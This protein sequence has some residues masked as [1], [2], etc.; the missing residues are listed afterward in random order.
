MP[1][2][3]LDDQPVTLLGFENA[4]LNYSCKEEIIIGSKEFHRR[5]VKRQHISNK[6][7]RESWATGREHRIDGL[8]N[9]FSNWLLDSGFR[10]LLI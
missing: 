1:C 4:K 8:F 7:R 5:S 3:I 10:S 2:I 6:Q 9:L